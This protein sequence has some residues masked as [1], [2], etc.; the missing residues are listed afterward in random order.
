MSEKLK[1]CPF[2]GAKETDLDFQLAHASVFT[3]PFFF[4]R[5]RK[6]GGMIVDTNTEHCLNDVKKAW[7]RRAER[8]E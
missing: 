3:K 2:C 1:P 5:C 7:N 4:V 8:E 6:C